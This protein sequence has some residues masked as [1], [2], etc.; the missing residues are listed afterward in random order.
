MGFGLRK[1]YFT[2]AV[3]QPFVVAMADEHREHVLTLAMQDI[4]D[5]IVTR[6]VFYLTTTEIIFRGQRMH[7]H[8]GHEAHIEENV[9]EVVRNVLPWVHIIIG[10]CRNGI[11][12]IHKEVDKRFLQLYLNEYCWK[13]NRRFFRDSTDPRYDLF[14]RLVK[15]AVIYKSDI[16]WRDYTKMSE[17]EDI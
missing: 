15:I 3:V 8:Q 12:A 17:E 2:L 4:V 10:E 1:T 11:A 9:D 16:M 5:G 14:D 13:F 6:D 7:I